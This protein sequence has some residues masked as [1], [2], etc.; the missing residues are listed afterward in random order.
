MRA[1]VFSFVGFLSVFICV[2]LWFRLFRRESTAPRCG[3]AARAKM[4]ASARNDY[5]P[6]F[7]LTAK[8]WHPIALVDAVAELKIAALALGIDIV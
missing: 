1:G 3:L 8:T 4:A 7:C 6:D 2:H 5:A